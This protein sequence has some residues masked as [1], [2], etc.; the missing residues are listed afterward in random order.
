MATSTK[1]AV[2]RG[3]EKAIKKSLRSN[4][5]A[6]AEASEPKVAWINR[7]KRDKRIINTIN[8]YRDAKKSSEAMMD[9]MNGLVQAFAA[10]KDYAK[11]ADDGDTI[12][13][14]MA[15][16]AQARKDAKASWHLRASKRDRAGVNA[17]QFKGVL[18]LAVM[19]GGLAAW[20]HVYATCQNWSLAKDVANTVRT[21]LLEENK[22]ASNDAIDRIRNKRLRRTSGGG[23]SDGTTKSSVSTLVV[24]IGDALAKMRKTYG[25]KLGI[26]DYINK[27]ESALAELGL[28]A[29]LNARSSARA[30]RKTAGKVIKLRRAS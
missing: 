19:K 21:T 17:S 20:N 7:V 8:T 13:W 10:T 26:N 25:R 9:F 18:K 4:V 6:D 28:K 16:E 12:K 5:K 2:K 1:R 27:V 24:R 29:G 14:L 30:K 22:K 23:S 11:A 15:Q 3:I